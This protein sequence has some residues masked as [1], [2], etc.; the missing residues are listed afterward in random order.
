L[1]AQNSYCYGRAH[2]PS[3]SSQQLH[4][5]GN[6]PRATL[7]PRSVLICSRVASRGTGNRTRNSLIPASNAFSALTDR[8]SLPYD[9]YSTVVRGLSLPPLRS[10]HCRKGEPIRNATPACSGSG[11]KR[12]AHTLHS[13]EQQA[14]A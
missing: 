2:P 7:S 9:L 8:G 12:S 11:S 3:S 1:Q 10:V 4:R 6:S 5:D 13:W 14:A